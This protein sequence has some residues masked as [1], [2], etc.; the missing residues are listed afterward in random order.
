MS[1]SRY[2]SFLCDENVRL[3]S[4]IYGMIS[5][6]ADRCERACMMFLLSRA[7]GDVA[8]LSRWMTVAVREA[9]ELLSLGGSGDRAA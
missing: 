1:S 5:P 3:L 4:E 9:S 6:G 8:A 7:G 2:R